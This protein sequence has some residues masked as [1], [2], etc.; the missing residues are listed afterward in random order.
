MRTCGATQRALGAGWRL[1]NGKVSTVGPIPGLC[2]R[3][4]TG[5]ICILPGRNSP[6]LLAAPLL[7]DLR[8]RPAGRGRASPAPEGVASL[9]A[10]ALQ[11]WEGVEEATS[12]RRRA[13]LCTGA[14]VS[15]PQETRV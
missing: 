13:Y 2:E 1:R 11:L 9:R 3:G 5:L 7:P 10:F 15:P 6:L 4:W 8:A 12:R 14:R